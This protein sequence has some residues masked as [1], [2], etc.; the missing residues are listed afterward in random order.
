MFT[1]GTGGRK[2]IRVIVQ[3]RHVVTLHELR[4]IRLCGPISSFRPSI[5]PFEQLYLQNNNEEQSQMSQKQCRRL[6]SACILLWVVLFPQNESR[7]CD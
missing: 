6:F 5:L 1:S 3:P 2:Q 7:A 4:L